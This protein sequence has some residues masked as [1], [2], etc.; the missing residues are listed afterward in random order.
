M[1]VYYVFLFFLLFSDSPLLP[2][3]FMISACYVFFAF[4]LFP[5]HSY[6]LAI[7]LHVTVLTDRDYF[8]EHFFSLSSQLCRT[9]TIL[10]CSTFLKMKET[11]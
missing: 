10:K 7:V 1:F 3:D 5:F 6:S 4:C 2:N 9:Q 11:K 8:G